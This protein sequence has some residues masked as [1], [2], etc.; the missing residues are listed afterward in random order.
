MGEEGV[1][2]KEE[3]KKM[4]EEGV[5]EKEEEKNMAVEGEEE[6]KMEVVKKTVEKEILQPI[7]LVPF[8]KMYALQE[9]GE[10]EDR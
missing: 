8:P 6:E 1:V 5:I 9:M 10:V 2:E 3:E 4:G 7:H